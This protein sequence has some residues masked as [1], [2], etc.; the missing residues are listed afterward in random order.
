MPDVQSG[1]QHAR[2]VSDNSDEPH[3]NGDA[4][5]AENDGEVPV[6]ADMVKEVVESLSRAQKG[7]ERA[8]SAAGSARDQNLNQSWSC[9]LLSTT[10]PVKRQRT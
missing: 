8:R 9:F 7:R 6:G 3:D 4:K 5:I 10:I 1:R 2:C